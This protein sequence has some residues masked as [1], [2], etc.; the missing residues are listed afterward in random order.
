MLPAGS[1]D[2]APRLLY[3]V[4]TFIPLALM[5]V[6]PSPWPCFFFALCNQMQRAFCLS[7]SIHAAPSSWHFASLSI[8][9]KRLPVLTAATPVLPLPAKKS[10]TSPPGFVCVEI[11]LSVMS[12][13]FWH[14][15]RFGPPW[16]SWLIQILQWFLSRLW[17]NLAALASRI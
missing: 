8:S 2:K 13:G 10:T 15:C 16:V 17:T 3:N 5:E 9:R 4:S 12:I 6:R 1:I 14:G 7:L 11:I